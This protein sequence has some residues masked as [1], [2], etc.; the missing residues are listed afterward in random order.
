M[1]TPLTYSDPLVVKPPHYCQG[2][3]ESIDA[4]EASMSPFAFEGFLKGQVLKYLW[5]YPHKGTATR[6]LQKAQFYLDK[7]AGL[8]EGRENIQ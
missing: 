7:L 5:R 3:I 6:D 1:P 2:V 8:V 4:I